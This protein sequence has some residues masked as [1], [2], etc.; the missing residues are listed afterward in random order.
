MWDKEIYQAILQ[1][2]NTGGFYGILGL[3]VWVI[4]PIVK[5]SI[6][7]LLVSKI[8]TFTIRNFSNLY[9]IRHF[10]KATSITLLSKE[11]SKAVLDSLKEFEASSANATKKLMSLVEEWQERSNKEKSKTSSTP[12]EVCK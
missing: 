9:L 3:A 11:T 4:A 1:I 6:V 8:L 10:H 7:L 5:V 2:I 12:S